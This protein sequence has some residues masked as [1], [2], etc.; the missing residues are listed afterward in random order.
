MVN[1]A[2]PFACRSADFA[3][4]KLP[5][6]ATKAAGTQSYQ[7]FKILILLHFIA[8]YPFGTPAARLTAWSKEAGEHPDGHSR[9]V[10][11]QRGAGHGE[12]ISHWVVAPGGAGP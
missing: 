3:G 6:F 5:E 2:F 1:E 10:G 4:S 11:E 7:N 9:I 8:F 12:C